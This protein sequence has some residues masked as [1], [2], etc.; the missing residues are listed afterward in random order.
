MLSYGMAGVELSDAA[1]NRVELAQ[2]SQATVRFP[3]PEGQQADAPPTIPLWWFDEEL[4]YWVQEGEAQRE[5]NDYV[6]QVT[7]FSWWNC[8]VPAN[9]VLLKGNVLDQASGANLNNAEIRL[10]TA[11]MGT[12]VLQSAGEFGCDGAVGLGSVHTH[13]CTKK[14]LGLS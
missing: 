1:G 3:I 12:G 7:H 14:S 5:G 9:F 8:D 6:G 10:I 4:G 13:W 2:G 11:D